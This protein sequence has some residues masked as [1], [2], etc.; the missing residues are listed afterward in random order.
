MRGIGSWVAPLLVARK[1]A[2]E[3]CPAA[4]RSGRCRR[5]AAEKPKGTTVV[6]T[7]SPDGFSIQTEDG[8]FKLQLKGLFSSTDASSPT[9]DVLRTTS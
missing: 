4:G 3:E 8:D 9:T 2:R 5:Q 1:S 6:A 7:A